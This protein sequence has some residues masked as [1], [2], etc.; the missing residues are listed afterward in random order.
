MTRDTGEGVSVIRLPSGVIWDGEGDLNKVYER[1]WKF[2]QGN[3]EERG[4]WHTRRREAGG[5]STKDG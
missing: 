3:I 5:A 2:G 4:T 1:R